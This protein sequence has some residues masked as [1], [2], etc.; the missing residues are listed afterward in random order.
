MTAEHA[1]AF[2]AFTL[3][4]VVYFLGAF[5]TRKVAFLRN[6]NIP[7]PVSGGL[8]VAVAVWLIYLITGHAIE[9]DLVVRDALLIL[10]FT[11]IGLNARFADLLRGGPLL[12]TLLVLTIVFMLLQNGVGLLGATLFGLPSELSVLLGTASL[13]G[14]HG[15]AIA[16]GPEIELI[17]GFEAAEEIGLAAATLGLIVAA[18]VGGPLAKFLI[19][20]HD[21]HGDD[22]AAPMVGLEYEEP[23]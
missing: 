3:G 13:I 12:I 10:F 6:Y 4:M 7:E 11:T 8:V 1:P 22:E 18:L 21:L 19:D 17:S 16:W 5:L 9:F 2:I 14:G 23:D 20:K 15:T